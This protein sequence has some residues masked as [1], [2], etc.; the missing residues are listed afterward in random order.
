MTPYAERK[1]GFAT[2]LLKLHRRRSGNVT[3]HK[4]LDVV[5]IALIASICGAD[6]CTDFACGREALFRYFLELPG[7]LPSHDTFS[8]LFRLLAPPASAGCFASFLD[9]LAGRQRRR[10]RTQHVDA[11]NASCA[12]WSFVVV[13]ALKPRL[14]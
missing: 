11:D 3:R 6:S 1:S 2:E 13:R 8:R 10:R 9:G 4:L 7:G 14:E 12:R 5:T